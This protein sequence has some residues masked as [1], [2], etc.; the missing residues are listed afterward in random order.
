MGKADLEEFY[1]LVQV[2][3]TVE[4][5]GQRNE[6][7]AQLFGASE[8]PLAAAGRQ[9]EEAARG[10]DA[11]IG[12]VGALSVSVKLNEAVTDVVGNVASR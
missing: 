7:T 5:V 2:G 3:D 11:A 12:R 1:G 9:V 6:E 4:L 10:T 8:N